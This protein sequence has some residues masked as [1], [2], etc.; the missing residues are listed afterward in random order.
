[1]NQRYEVRGRLA[2]AIALVISFL[3]PAVGQAEPVTYV[4]L[5]GSTIT[6]TSGSTPTGPTEPLTGTF[7]LVG[8]DLGNGFDAVA[9]SFASS[10]F[11]ITLNLTALNDL[12]TFVSPISSLSIFAEIVDLVGLS[13]SPAEL[14]GS[15]TYLGPSSSPTFLSYPLLSIS[16][17]GIPPFATLSFSAS[18]VPEPP[19]WL[20]FAT[21][22]ASIFI[23]RL[24]RK[25]PSVSA[26]A[27]AFTSCAELKQFHTRPSRSI[28]GP[29]PLTPTQLFH[30]S[31]AL[32]VESAVDSVA[33]D[34]F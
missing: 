21:A 12:E 28:Y 10:S 11:S 34:G 19:G 23:L 8:P 9:L 29:D 4:L 30:Q 24:G 27:S 26:N 7:Q 3:L 6:P 33:T 14:V 25:S 20:L 16:N 18:V 17:V 15:G 13:P 5:P 1:M 2:L 31:A 32:T 22:F